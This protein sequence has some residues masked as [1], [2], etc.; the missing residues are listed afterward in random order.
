MDSAFMDN[1]AEQP[2]KPQTLEKERESTLDLILKEHFPASTGG[3]QVDT[4]AL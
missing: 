1:L 3:L 4:L 2:A